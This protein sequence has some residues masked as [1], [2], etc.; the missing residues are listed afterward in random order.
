MDNIVKDNF[1]YEDIISNLQ[2]QVNFSFSRFGDGELAAIFNLGKSQNCDKH[3]MFPD[4]RKAL[5][6]VLLSKPKYH[7]GLQR[8]GY[9]QYK[10]KVE[11]LN[12]SWCLAD[13]LHKAS[14]KNK[15]NKFFDVLKIRDVVLVGPSYL[16]KLRENKFL[17]PRIILHIPE[18]DCWLKTKQVIEFLSKQCNVK[19]NT[20][21]LFCASMATNIWIDELYMHYKNTITM[22]D[23]GSV[24]DPY[25]GKSKRSYHNSI[26]ERISQNDK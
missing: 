24:F 19:Q 6:N 16:E 17:Q 20:V 26:I 9:H 12:V 21:I 18:V 11:E 7:V 5:Y 2:N 10:E 4:M 15:L 22:I 13:T 25:C 3:K 23:C 8:L 14:I 1:S